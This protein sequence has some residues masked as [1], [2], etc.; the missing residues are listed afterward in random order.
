MPIIVTAKRLYLSNLRSTFLA[1]IN[2]RMVKNKKN[3]GLVG[4]K[5]RSTSGKNAA[6]ASL[7]QQAWTKTEWSQLVEYGLNDR[8]RFLPKQGSHP[9][10]DPG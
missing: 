1:K 10:D 6:D 3:F 8:L 9:S 5:R 2:V 7:N 4:S